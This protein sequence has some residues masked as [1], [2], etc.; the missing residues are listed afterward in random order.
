MGVIDKDGLVKA[1]ELQSNIDRILAEC[2]EELE[3]LRQDDK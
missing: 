2:F 1:L 3:K